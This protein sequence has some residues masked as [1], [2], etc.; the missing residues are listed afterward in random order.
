MLGTAWTP[1][2]AT[3]L[4]AGN[5]H[6]IFPNSR[7]WHG[8]PILHLKQNT[9]TTWAYGNPQ[10]LLLYAGYIPFWNPTTMLWGP[11]KLKEPTQKRIMGFRWTALL[12]SQPQAAELPGPG[13]KPWDMAARWASR[14]PWMRSWKHHVENNHLRNPINPQPWKI[15]NGHRLQP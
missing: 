13:S 10:P 4:L 7:F 15:I 3:S 14:W 2:D 11:R 5:V 8:C 9:V 6:F 12:S 1:R